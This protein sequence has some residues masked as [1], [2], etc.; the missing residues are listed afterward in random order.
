MSL[1]LFVVRHGIAVER[2]FG[3]DDAARPLTEKGRARFSKEVRGLAAWGVELD[4]IAHSPWLRAEQTAGLL[5][6]L[7]TADGRR[8]AEDGLA[9]A[10]GQ[11]LLDGFGEGRLA[12][13]GHEPW[14]SELVAWLVTGDAGD[15]AC[16]ELKKGA[17]A[18]LEGRPLPAAMTLR[19]LLPPKVLRRFGYPEG[20]PGAVPR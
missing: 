1:T 10:P 6:P 18:V 5:E 17:V 16:F 15:G 14:L 13:V 20:A 3:E 19:A 8:C 9:R 2:S 4:R 7:L 11:A 12:L